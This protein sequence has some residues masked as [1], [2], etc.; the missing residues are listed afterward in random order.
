M[1]KEKEKDAG[2]KKRGIFIDDFTKAFTSGM[3]K[4]GTAHR[5]ELA[6]GPKYDSDVMAGG[7]GG[8]T[9]PEDDGI[10]L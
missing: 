7:Q 6:K 1:S 4:A 3:K 5:N 8:F 10:R 2:D 9:E